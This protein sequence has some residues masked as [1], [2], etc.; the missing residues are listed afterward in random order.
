MHRSGACEWMAPKA[1]LLL[2][3]RLQPIG[4]ARA[5]TGRWLEGQAPGLATSDALLQ[6]GIAAPARIQVG[7]SSRPTPARALP[8]AAR[9]NPPN[10]GPDQ[11]NPVLMPS[12]Q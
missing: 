11:V 3:L 8:F 5:P 1:V 10:Q 4:I 12:N 7:L 9:H 6:Q 2:D